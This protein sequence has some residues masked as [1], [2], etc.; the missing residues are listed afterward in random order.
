MTPARIRL[1]VRTFIGNSAVVSAGVAIG[2]NSLIG[3]LSVAPKEG[4]ER[5]NAT[6]CGSPAVLFPRGESKAGFSEAKP[7]LP[8]TKLQIIHGSI[9]LLRITLPPAASIIVASSVIDAAMGLLKNIGPVGTLL[10]LPVVFGVSSGLMI[11]MVAAVKWLVMGR[12]KPFVH[13]LWCSFVWRLEFVNS[14]YEFFAAHL[15]LE[16]LQGT[17]FLPWYLR[18]MGA[19][20]GKACYIETTGFLEWD[21]VEIGDRVMVN[22]NAVIQTHLFEDRILQASRLRIG[23][24]CMVGATSVV[25]YD[26]IMENGSKLDA[27]TLLMKGETLPG[28]TH[29]M[30]IPA[31]SKLAAIKLN[32]KLNDKVRRRTVKRHYELEHSSFT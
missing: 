3:V 17:P 32:N 30:G 10:A 11:L 13:P 18:L 12:Y 23:N 24:D 8:L 14:L 20:I 29:W 31:S 26:S 2:D 1:G 7:Y 25:L 21:L 4:S 5:S 27:L 6:W 28:N 9:E 16:T 22:E 19:K 15:L